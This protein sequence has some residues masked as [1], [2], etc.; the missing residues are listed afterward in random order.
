MTW[1]FPVVC[2]ATEFAHAAGRCTHQTH[3]VE[4]VVNKQVELVAVVERL[5]RRVVRG[6]FGF[7]FGQFRRRLGDDR[8]ALVL[9]HSGRQLGVDLRGNVFHAHQKGCVQTGVGQ[10]LLLVHG[11]K[12]VVQ[13]V[14]LHRGMRLDGVEAAVVVGQQQA[15]RGNHFAGA[16]SAEG[17]DG[18]LQG[19]VVYVVQIFGGQLQTGLAHVLVVELLHQ[20]RKPHAFVGP[21][22]RG[23]CQN[24]GE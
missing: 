15:L 16:K 20:E 23:Q 3:V 14:V 18:V 22:G 17:N 19:A 1:P 13:V 21:N 10:L 9:R 7:F 24:Q 4:G 6:A 5:H 2:V 8:A 11:P 12:A